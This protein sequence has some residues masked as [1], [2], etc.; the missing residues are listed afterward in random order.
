MAAGCLVWSALFDPPAPTSPAT[1]PLGRLRR[2]DVGWLAVA[3]AVVALAIGMS[4]RTV[5]RL[6]VASVA[7][8]LGT[9]R[10]SAVEVVLSSDTAA[11]PYEIRTEAPDG[12]SVAY[13]LVSL[14]AGQSLRTTV[15][16]PGRAG[17]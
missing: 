15:D 2:R 14:R 3:A 16:L 7:L 5:D 6:D 13:P 11:G 4:T 10:G 12:N 8:S 17:T 1:A 9:V